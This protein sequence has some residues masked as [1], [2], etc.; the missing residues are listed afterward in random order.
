MSG[1]DCKDRT[2]VDGVNFMNW[3]RKF[4]CE[5]SLITILIELISVVIRPEKE[6]KKKEGE[7]KKLVL[8]NCEKEGE[9]K[10]QEK[11]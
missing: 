2:K 8:M 6:K 5:K 1:K 3:K 7:E 9:K 11:N 4:S 10:I